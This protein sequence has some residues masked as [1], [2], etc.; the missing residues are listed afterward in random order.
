MDRYQQERSQL[1][2]ELREAT[3]ELTLLA[4]RITMLTDKINLLDH[5]ME[6]QIPSRRS[7]GPATENLV[8]QLKKLKPV[9]EDILDSTSGDHFE[10]IY[11]LG[12]KL[13]EGAFSVVRKGTHRTSTRQFAIKVVRRDNLSRD[14]EAALLDEISILK[15][16][17]NEYIIRLYDVFTE[18][19][20]Y[21]MVTELLEGGELFD[22]IVSKEA[23]NEKEARN[24]CKI[25]FEAIAYCRRRQ[26]AHRDLKPE[27]LLL[28]SAANDFD[29]KIADFGFA[30]RVLS[31]ASLRTQCGTPGYVAPEIL[32]GVAYGLQVDMW[33]LG[34]IAYILLGGYPPFVETNQRELFK[35]IR[36]GEYEFHDEYWSTISHEAKGLISA[37]LTVCPQKRLSAVG[38]LQNSWVKE[39]DEVLEGKDLGT[40]LQELKRYNAKRKFKA[41]VHAVILANKLESLG[42]DFRKNL[43]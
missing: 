20:S 6:A 35:K 30:K 43:E 37:L 1:I 31:D 19:D 14:D 42:S 12:N 22:R 13:G 17:E 34:V 36:K 16:L 2:A 32:E 38:A 18:R 29:I 9:T 3:A 8:A 40:N 4:G 11:E 21:F 15:E 10:A 28:M 41:G 25:L 5:E 33:S 23:Y 7:S 27:N 24:V 39:S 26:I